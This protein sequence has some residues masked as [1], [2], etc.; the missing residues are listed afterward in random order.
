MWFCFY[1]YLFYF[2]TDLNKQ[3]CFDKFVFIIITVQ[4]K[5]VSVYIIHG[6]DI[7][8]TIDPQLKIT[9]K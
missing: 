9:S 4:I 1:N 8:I 3:K 5:T 7:R 2:R 6:D